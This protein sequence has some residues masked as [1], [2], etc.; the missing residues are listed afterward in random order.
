M[1]RE[2]VHVPPDLSVERLV[3]DYFW[4]HQVL[5]FPVVDGGRVGLV[6]IHDLGRRPRERWTESRVRDIMRPVSDALLAAP[7]ES[8]WQALEKVSR[9][10]IGRAAVVDDRRLAR[11]LRLKDI[12]HV[13]TSAPRPSPPGTGKEGGRTVKY[14]VVA[15]IAS[16]ITIF[17]LQ[18]TTPTSIRFLVWSLP[19]T[20]LATVILS[21][22]VAGI[23]LVGFPLWVN[24]WRLRARTRKLE[25]RLAT[26]E[27]RTTKEE[28]PPLPPTPPRAQPPLVQ[29]SVGKPVPDREVATP[30][31]LR[32]SR[33]RDRALDEH[34]TAWPHAR[35]F[36]RG[37]SP[38]GTVLPRILPQGGVTSLRRRI[39]V[40]PS[41]SR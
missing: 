20:P 4:R 25:A 31:E 3:D 16:A 39:R 2:V 22:V 27:A 36:L 30:R 8:L 34:A 40:R 14:L 17:A 1:V 15:L 13:L 7:R 24:R 41:S 23:V 18:N 11:Y 6:G 21:S 26:A 32:W 35:A 12:M 5:S 29:S 9:N 37:D 19:P 28:P 33:C 10:D 38:G